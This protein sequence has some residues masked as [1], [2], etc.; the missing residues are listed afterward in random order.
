MAQVV[1]DII[2]RYVENFVS[3]IRKLAENNHR[4]LKAY[5]LTRPYFP[6]ITYG[7]QSNSTVLRKDV[8]SMPLTSL[9]DLFQQATGENF[10]FGT[11]KL[12]LKSV[13]S[14]YLSSTS[15]NI[16]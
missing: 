12:Y 1:I 5:L 11:D 13:S 7:D 4:Y 2:Y 10:T 3:G 9:L 16:L 6:G 14:L 15:I 8:E